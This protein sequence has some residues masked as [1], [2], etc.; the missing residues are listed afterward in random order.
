MPTDKQILLAVRILG[1]LKEN[2]GRGLTVE[3]I[4]RIYI[5]ENSVSI[6]ELQEILTGLEAD[7]FVEQ[8]QGSFTTGTTT[9]SVIMYQITG[10]GMDRY[11]LLRD[12]A[13][14]AKRAR[15]RQADYEYEEAKRKKSNKRWLIGCSV[16]FVLTVAI[17][18]IVAI[19]LG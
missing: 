19:S 10:E 13:P 2:Y 6:W 18:I 14:G 12:G 8:R 3:E 17:A 11:I 16:G 9:K 4:K 7:K 1:F 15:E 5:K